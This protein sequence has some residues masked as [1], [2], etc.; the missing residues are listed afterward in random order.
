MEIWKRDLTIAMVQLYERDKRS[1]F[2]RFHVE[3]IVHADMMLSDTKVQPSDYEGEG[4]L[5]P[6]FVF[7]KR[8]NCSWRIF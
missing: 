2:A 6:S 1:Q 3:I 4:W 5:P 7:F 8:H